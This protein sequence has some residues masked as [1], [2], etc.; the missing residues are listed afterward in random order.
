VEGD[1]VGSNLGIR[2]VRRPTCNSN[3]KRVR[4]DWESRIQLYII[5]AAGKIKQY[6]EQKG[7]ANES[8][9]KEKG[10]VIFR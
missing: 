4:S 8:L 3:M 5:L 7:E 9:C 1:K 10:Q 2:E 6:R